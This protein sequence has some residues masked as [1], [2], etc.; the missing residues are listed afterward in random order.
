MYEDLLREKI[1]EADPSVRDSLAL[2]MI[3]D[4]IAEVD[5][6]TILD[7]SNTAYWNT[8]QNNNYLLLDRHAGEWMVKEDSDD[9]YRY[10][11]DPREGF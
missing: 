11:Y 9:E 3:Q 6:E 1:A 8:V 2:R 5:Y 4:M 10:K 7:F